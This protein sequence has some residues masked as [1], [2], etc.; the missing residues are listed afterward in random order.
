MLT[1]KSLITLLIMFFLGC[2]E[3]A[4]KGKQEKLLD[5]AECLPDK[6][7]V[8]GPILDWCCFWTPK[9]GCQ[10]LGG[11]LYQNFSDCDICRHSCN[12]DEDK[13]SGMVKISPR[14][15]CAVLGIL[16]LLSIAYL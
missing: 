4:D 12:C 9:M 15:W 5:L 1:R 8:T 3:A 6:F 10:Q 11:T 13:V 14:R 2:Q 7:T 16:A